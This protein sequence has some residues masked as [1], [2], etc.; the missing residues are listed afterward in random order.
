MLYNE[1]HSVR[2]DLMDTVT[3][4]LYNVKEKSNLMKSNVSKN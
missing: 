4:Q 2:P 1:D 3:P